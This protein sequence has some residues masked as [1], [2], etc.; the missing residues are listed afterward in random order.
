MALYLIRRS[1][2]RQKELAQGGASP[3][4]GSILLSE[5]SNMCFPKMGLFHMEQ[6]T[7]IFIFPFKSQSSGFL[8]QQSMHSSEFFLDF[9]E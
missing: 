9:F 1:P 3:A 5:L 6:R 4:G 2:S 8:W 7:E